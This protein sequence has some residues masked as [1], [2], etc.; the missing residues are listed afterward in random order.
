[1]KW[2]RFFLFLG[3]DKILDPVQKTLVVVV[4]KNIVTLSKL[5]SILLKNIGNTVSL[6]LLYRDLVIFL[7]WLLPRLALNGPIT[8]SILF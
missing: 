2:K 8:T 3:W 4:I 5:W 7:G 6:D 1:M